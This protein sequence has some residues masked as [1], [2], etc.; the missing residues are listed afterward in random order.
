MTKLII[1]R[2]GQTD[3][4]KRHLVQGVT[5]IPLN[6]IG[7]QQAQ[8]LAQKLKAFDL[9]EIFSSNLKRAHQTASIVA[10]QIGCNVTTASSL[11]EQ[12]YGTIE[13]EPTSEIRCKYADICK[14][15][16]DISHPDTNT[17]SFPQAESRLNVFARASQALKN[18][19]L[20]APHASIGISTHGGVILSLLSVQFRQTA[21]VGNAEFIV[22]THDGNTCVD[23]QM[24]IKP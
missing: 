1:F 4:N 10:Q 13:A 5:D 20:A 22:L 16:D 8:D 21:H 24:Q 7:I 19:A 17:I 11:R 15:M 23:F 12:N 14:I 2:H 6:D 9:S 18:I 3:M